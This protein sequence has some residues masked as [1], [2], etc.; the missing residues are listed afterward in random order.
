[1]STLP[2]DETLAY[3]ERFVPGYGE[4]VHGATVAELEELQAAAGGAPL[5]EPYRQHLLRLGHGLSL[6]RLTPARYD[7]VSLTARY[8]HWNPTPP[9]FWLLGRA[10]QDPYY[11]VYLYAPPGAT[12]RVVA[13]PSP[14]ASG[15][16]EFARRHLVAL[17]GNLPQWLAGAVFREHRLAAFGR[18]QVLNTRQAQARRLS[19]CDAALATVGL[20]PLW[21]SDD[22]C[23]YYETKEGR[24]G[25]AM[26]TE[27]PGTPT[28]V[29]LRTDTTE[30]LAA[31]VAAA[32]V[33][34]A[35][36]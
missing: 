1:M 5:P 23:R 3:I 21:F 19:Q 22:W 6:P 27:F 11:D 12:A 18:L 34:V 25:V 9:G 15:F 36:G 7:I 4:R 13:F 26:V 8:R 32:E 17:A 31:W 30:R 29:L 10:T 33:A 24:G 35:P 2:L 20:Q 16:A 14:P 28:T